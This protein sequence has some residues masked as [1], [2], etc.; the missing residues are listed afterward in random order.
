MRQTGVYKQRIGRLGK[1]VFCVSDTH[2]TMRKCPKVIIRD[3]LEIWEGAEELLPF[4]LLLYSLYDL[5]EF[6]WE[7][8]RLSDHRLSTQLEDRNAL[9][10]VWC[11]WRKLSLSQCLAGT[12][13]ERHVRLLR[14]RH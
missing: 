10:P 1:N 12:I 3:K 7:N 4:L 11:L 6:Y 9:V 5:S 8:W 14:T 2:N 13:R